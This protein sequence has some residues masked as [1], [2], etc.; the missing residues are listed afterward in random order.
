[1]FGDSNS[2]KGY[3]IVACGTVRPELTF[4]K[5]S[6]FL[7][8]NKIL[9]TA[10]GL[11]ENQRELKEQLTEKLKQAEIS[12]GR[13][14]VAYGNRCYMDFKN[15]FYTIDSIIDEGGSEMSRIEAGN[16]IDMLATAEER[17]RIAGDQRIY[18]MTMGWL[19]YW[20]Y[21]FRDWD[22]GKANETFP[23]NDKALILDPSNAFEKYSGEKPEEVLE[24]SD[25][26][27]VPI[28]AHPVSWERIKGLLIQARDRIAE[29]G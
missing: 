14:I 19:L 20:R 3:S 6:G 13:T 24:F 22:V 23:Q 26:M 17:K 4:L 25:W 15:P 7:D 18:W 9:Y 28:E 16:C 10:P 12:S 5:K 11:H 21:I 1:M 8:A 2:F 27:G 29:G